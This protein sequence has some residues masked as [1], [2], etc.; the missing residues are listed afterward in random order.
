MDLFIVEL[1]YKKL[2]AVQNR[3]NPQQT[4]QVECIVSKHCRP[5]VSIFCTGEML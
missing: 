5:H 3:N 1:L 2:K 4:E